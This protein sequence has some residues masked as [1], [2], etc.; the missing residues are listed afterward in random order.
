MSYVQA[1]TEA[2]ST[3][4]LLKDDGTLVGLDSLTLMDFIVELEN[5]TQLTIPT[6]EIRNDA[7]ASVESV[8]A[9][10]ERVKA[11]A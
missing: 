7:F 4:K 5:T 9:L 1:V 6:K 8:V 11:L 2:A 3:L 10:L